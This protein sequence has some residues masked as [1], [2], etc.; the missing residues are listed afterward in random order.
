[1]LSTPK[2]SRLTSIRAYN[3]KIKKTVASSVIL[4]V[5]KVKGTSEQPRHANPPS[6][7]LVIE[8]VRPLNQLVYVPDTKDGYALGRI[9]DLDTKHVTIRLEAP[10]TGELKASFA[11]VIPAVEDQT[12]DVNDNCMF[13]LQSSKQTSRLPNVL[14][15]RHIV[16]Q[17]PSALRSQ[18]DLRKKPSLITTNYFRH[19]LPTSS[20]PSIPMNN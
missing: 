13:Q 3:S 4:I 2:H 1:M 8:D 10:R 14:E 6:K 16:A 17:L 15:W 7:E 19:T 12:K 11:D 20:Y 18:A 9:V 5:F